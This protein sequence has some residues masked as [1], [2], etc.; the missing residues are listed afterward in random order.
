MSPL[1]NAE[2]TTPPTNATPRPSCPI[3]FKNCAAILVY[4]TFNNN[5]KLIKQQKL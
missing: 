5:K 4:F 1:Y 3:L 2:L